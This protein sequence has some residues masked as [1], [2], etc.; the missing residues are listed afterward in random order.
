MDH[1]LLARVRHLFSRRS[2]VS[3]RGMFGGRCFLVNGHF[4][5]AVDRAGLIVRVHPAAHEAL[6]RQ[7][8]V[9]PFDLN[10]RPMRGWF[11]VAA[12]GTAS[13]GLQAWV[14]RALDYVGAL[15]PKITRSQVS[16]SVG[17]RASGRL[18]KTSRH[19][20]EPRRSTKP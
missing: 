5:V 3:E 9:R 8:Y 13:R 15:P 17:A 6:M 12:G 10:G 16:P 14:S 7:R 20:P 19:R 1:Q 18:L 2:A 11:V 4:C